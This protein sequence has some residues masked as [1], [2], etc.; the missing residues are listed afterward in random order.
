[1]RGK[2]PRL[3]DH[4]T[5]RRAEVNAQFARDDLCQRGFAKTGRPDEQHMVECLLAG[6]RR[7]D[8]YAQVR[9]CLLL[10][11][12]FRQ[13]LRPQRGIDV[14]VT[15]VGSHQ[16]ARAVHFASSFKPCLISVAVS[17]PSPA[18][19]AAAAMAAAACG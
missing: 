9:T 3:G 19:R 12:E 13:A 17:A 7:L 14:V 4:W 18:L 10:A 8:E 2:I 1:Q 6:A 16:A 15:F 11:D 5:R